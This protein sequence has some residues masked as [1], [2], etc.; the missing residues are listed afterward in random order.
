VPTEPLYRERLD[1]PAGWWLI[2]LAGLATVWVITAVPAG[3]PTATV[4]TAVAAV[5]VAG[6]LVGYGA[7][8]VSVDAERLRAGRASIER[9]YLGEAVPLTGEDARTASGRDA[10][11]RAHLLLRPYVHGAVR[12]DVNDPDDPTPYWLIATRHPDRLAA[13][14]R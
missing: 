7:A 4:V 8:E 9:R 11:H 1:A 12:V 10:D 3:A 14:L 2:G 13:A 5:L 6:V